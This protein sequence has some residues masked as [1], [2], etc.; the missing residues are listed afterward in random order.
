MAQ[1]GEGREGSEGGEE[2]RAEVEK[3]EG[4]GR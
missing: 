4:G 1:E 3:G 2:E